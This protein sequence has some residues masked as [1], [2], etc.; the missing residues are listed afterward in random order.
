[1][2][3]N[4]IGKNSIFLPEVESTNSYAIELLKN[5]NLVE[6]TIVFTDFQSKGRGQRGMRWQAE[7]ANN[8]TCSIIVK[9]GFLAIENYFFLYKV[10]ALACYDAL[11]EFLNNGQFDIKI[12]WPNDILVNRKKI[13]GILIEN[14]LSDNQIVWSVIGIGMNVNQKQFD[15][16][17]NATSI[18]HLLDNEVDK[19][20]LQNR[21]C[22]LF[23]A[24]YIMLKQKEFDK[25][26]TLYVSK[27]FALNDS[28]FVEY[29]GEKMKINVSHIQ[30][31]GLLVFKDEKLK[32]YEADVKDL[33][34]FLNH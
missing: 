2:E 31:N 17:L 34:W 10:A 29:K 15:P 22:A 1:M 9:P 19:S 7:P 5:V 20:E 13:C 14:I 24:Y 3:T 21:I 18:K 30:T 4:F 28:C 11:T 26:N 6:G 23:E 27:L 12:K 32:V 33:K 16:E 25:I 8:I